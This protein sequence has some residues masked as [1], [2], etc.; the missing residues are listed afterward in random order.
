[1]AT[2]AKATLTSSY[3]FNSERCVQRAPTTAMGSRAAPLCNQTLEI[4]HQDALGGRHSALTDPTCLGVACEIWSPTPSSAHATV[5]PAGLACPCRST[6]WAMRLPL[7][8]PFADRSEQAS[9]NV[10]ET[11]KPPAAWPGLLAASAAHQ[12]PPAWARKVGGRPL[13]P[14]H[15]ARRKW[16]EKRDII[17]VGARKTPLGVSCS[18]PLVRHNCA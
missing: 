2:A 9:A 7:R 14:A 10:G 5:A 4:A 1:M 8:A 13:L 16:E 12:P 11:R 18:A 15:R 17:H 6:S 3:D